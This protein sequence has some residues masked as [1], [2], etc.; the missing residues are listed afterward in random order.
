MRKKKRFLEQF[1]E[2]QAK[3]T[4]MQCALA[5]AIKLD[6]KRRIKFYS[7]ELNKLEH[8]MVDYITRS[9]RL[10]NKIN[11]A[12]EA[13]KYRIDEVKQKQLT[14]AILD[15][16]MTIDELETWVEGKKW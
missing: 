5:K 15:Q 6:K 2:D 8:D 16:E 1:F 11:F 9:K 12:K 4:I 3:R 7:D 14:L 10:Y 13:P